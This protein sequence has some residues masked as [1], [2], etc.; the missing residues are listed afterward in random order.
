M[1][2]AERTRSIPVVP[3]AEKTRSILSKEDCRD[4]PHVLPR[5]LP[6]SNSIEKPKNPREGL[7]WQKG[8]R[9]NNFPALWD[10][11]TNYGVTFDEDENGGGVIV[12]DVDPVKNEKGVVI[13]TAEEVRTGLGRKNGWSEDT[14]TVKTP[15]GWHFYWKCGKL[16]DKQYGGDSG[17][18]PGVDTRNAGKG[19]V[20]GPGSVIDG[21]EYVALNDLPIAEIPGRLFEA[22]VR[23]PVEPIELSNGK[24]EGLNGTAAGVTT[25]AIQEGAR[26]SALTSIAGT[27]VNALLMDAEVERVL[28]EANRKKCNPPLEE[29]EVIHI[30]RSKLKSYRDRRPHVNYN[31]RAIEEG[32]SDRETLLN[33]L[34]AVKTQVR[35]NIRHEG[36]I[37]WKR[38]TGASDF[39]WGKDKEVGLEWTPIKKNKRSTIHYV[40]QENCLKIVWPMKGGVVT[41]KMK[42]S[43]AGF[44]EALEESAG[45]N[46]VD[47][48]IL[49]LEKLP[50]WD[51]EPRIDT[52]ITHFFSSDSP[53]KLLAWATWG[54]IGGAIRRAY[55][56]GTKQDEMPILVGPIGIGK[57]TFWEFLLPEGSD[58]FSDSLNLSET[59]ARRVESLGGKVILEWAELQGITRTGLE[60]L[61]AF[62]SRNTDTLRL[63]YRPDPE[64][65]PRRCVIVGT[66]NQ[67]NCLPSDPAG[68]RRFV[69]VRVQGSDDVPVKIRTDM[70]EI[71][72][73]IWAEGL[74]RYRQGKTSYLPTALKKTLSVESRRHENKD[75]VIETE[76][77]KVLGSVKHF[78]ENNNCIKMADV[79]KAM[80][81]VWPPT[82]QDQLKIGQTLRHAGYV[83][84][85]HPKHGSIWRTEEKPEGLPF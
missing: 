20:V 9:K 67:E 34:R 66:T 11:H 73:Q 57:S 26:N 48:F 2:L 10:N 38:S 35:G 41:K 54:V 62:M 1:T 79:A 39:N 7:P 69:P 50:E 12:I 4:F 14:Y 68:N 23:E 17:L 72:D 49:Y 37:E 32:R 21:E 55:K 53:H 44:H 47:P 15:R 29:K 74:V 85:K 25:G 83:K 5:A 82:R 28:I 81:I 22:I 33:A 70:P 84:T 77:L 63:A 31:Q 43:Q 18:G 60:D 42:F 3:F 56:P 78:G 51:G 64:D 6:L 76:V 61:K 46:E 36:R 80:N 27:L 75:E 71:R 65:I 58:W 40:I 13:K 30:A 19:Y 52:L 59:P 16:P 8:A 45:Q 24:T